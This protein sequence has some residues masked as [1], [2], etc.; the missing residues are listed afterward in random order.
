MK[1][2][3]LVQTLLISSLTGLGA[4]GPRMATVGSES[5]PGEAASPAAQVQ[6]GGTPQSGGAGPTFT[7]S[8]N[9]TL[10]LGSFGGT[11]V[12]DTAEAQRQGGA[13]GGGGFGDRRALAIL[14]S[15]SQ[16]LAQLI[17]NSSPEI[18][19]DLPEG[20][21]Q[22]RLAL[23]V[24]QVRLDGNLVAKRYDRELYFDYKP[25]TEDQEAQ[26]IATK[27][28]K[29]AHASIEVDI[30]SEW[31]LRPTIDQVHLD[32]MHEVA[33]LLGIGLSEEDDER[34][35]EWAA[36]F[37]YEVLATDTIV[38][39]MTESYDGEQFWSRS[40]T[41]SGSIETSHPTKYLW[42]VNRP[43]LTGSFCGRVGDSYGP[44]VCD[45]VKEA[46]REENFGPHQLHRNV[47]TD[48]T[49]GIALDMREEHIARRRG[50]TALVS[51]QQLLMTSLHGLGTGMGG[52]AVQSSASEATF[53][54]ELITL[55]IKGDN[56]D[57]NVW[58][59]QSDSYKIRPFSGFEEI[60][61]NIDSSGAVGNS[62][63][64]YS[65]EFDD[66]GEQVNLE[67]PIQCNRGYQILKIEEFQTPQ[68]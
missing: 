53:S 67:L 10:R 42:L 60:T 51:Q 64:L 45:K 41:Y 58:V 66:N 55:R 57:L 13:T 19:Q 30:L 62:S 34:A 23:V 20:W 65:I 28:F 36:H 2:K 24:S 56:P 61:L 47:F 26:I 54:D 7:T 9:H 4:C 38:C 43:S 22:E 52:G 50:A 35:R 12:L 16:E 14:G 31:Q 21:T 29:T 11:G 48:E 17:R 1:K 8:S 18:Y 32:I 5:G 40:R 33:H 15:A 6:S 44:T 25:P 63:Y 27:M 49:Y 39:K 68:N 3:Y 37:L 59:D 46:L